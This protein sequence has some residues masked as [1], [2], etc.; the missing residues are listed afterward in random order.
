M[1]DT[2]ERSNQRSG[3]LTAGGDREE[4]E[5]LK[6]VRLQGETLDRRQVEE[7]VRAWFDNLRINLKKVLLLPPDFTRSH[8]GAG[9]ITQIIYRMLSPTCRVDIMPALGTHFPMSEEERT[10]M[11]GGIPA[12]RF[13]VHDWRNDVVK[14]GE[15]PGSYVAELSGDLLHYSVAVE[16]NKRLVDKSYDLIVSIGQVVPHEVVG[17]ANYNKNIFVGCGGKDLIDKSHFLGAVCGME[18]IMGR[19]HSPVRRLFDHA[20]ERFLGDLPLQYILTVTSTGSNGELR[21]NGLYIGR[22][23]G[24]FEEAVRCSRQRNIFFLEEPLPKVVVYLE[25]AEFKSTWLGN[26]AIYRSRMAVADGGELVII[27]PGLKQFGEDPIIDRLIRKY[28]YVGRDRI[29][30]LVATHGDLRNNLSA[31]A[32]LIHGSSEG[33]FRVLYAPGFLEQAEIEQVG[34]EYMSPEEAEKRYHPT[35]LQEGFNTLSSGEK[36]Y[37]IKN[38]ALGLWVYKSAFPDEG[39]TG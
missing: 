33:R 5:R 19:D 37:F 18:Q 10:K 14:I 25:P 36:V 28:G 39:T 30:E 1:V 26:K 34:F 23:R 35:V 38:P 12:E 24:L 22:N 16:I 20:E 6:S 11:F 8:S 7:A 4:K 27:A 32:H 2:G 15:I 21:L 17:M 3:G 13:Y 29:L 31:A 9:M